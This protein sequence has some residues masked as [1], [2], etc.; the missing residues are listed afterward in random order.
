ML[1]TT[2][3]ANPSSPEYAIQV[4]REKLLEDSYWAEAIETGSE[5][6]RY[7]NNKDSASAFLA[8]LNDL[9]RQFVP[10][11]NSLPQH[12]HKQEASKSQPPEDE[13]CPAY[14][15]VSWW[16]MWNPRS[17]TAICS[18][19]WWTALT[20]ILRLF[21]LCAFDFCFLLEI[22]RI[23]ESLRGYETILTRK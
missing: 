23:V 18:A 16:S 20:M 10:S 5:M 21:L 6:R 2:R 11:D 15:S 7:I 3:W 19:P 1:V 22:I 13:R 14:N 12:P 17:A 4:R 9:Q 8:L